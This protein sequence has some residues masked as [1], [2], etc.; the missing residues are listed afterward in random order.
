MAKPLKKMPPANE[1]LSS[2]LLKRIDAALGSIVGYDEAKKSAWLTSYNTGLIGVPQELMKTTQGLEQV[3]AYL[4]LH[5]F[6][7]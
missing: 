1:D 5:A 4:E 2:T 7:I 3:V 6:R